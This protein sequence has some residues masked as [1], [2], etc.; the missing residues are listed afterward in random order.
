MTSCIKLKRK[1]SH[2]TRN[3]HS[4]SLGWYCLI[5]A[6]GSQSQYYGVP[7]ANALLPRR[8]NPS[9]S[10]SSS[11]LFNTKNAFVKHKERNNYLEG[12]RGGGDKTKRDEKDNDVLQ[13]DD[14]ELDAY[15][16]F[17]LAADGE[18]SSTVGNP[19]KRRRK[20]QEHVVEEAVQ[21]EPINDDDSLTE[22]SESDQ[23][24]ENIE[25]TGSIH[26]ENVEEEEMDAPVSESVE[27]ATMEVASVAPIENRPMHSESVEEET[28]TSGID[29]SVEMEP[30]GESSSAVVSSSD[31]EENEEIF[32]STISD[33]QQE[34]GISSSETEG[35]EIIVSELQSENKDDSNQAT[36]ADQ[37]ESLDTPMVKPSIEL[38]VQQTRETVVTTGRS[39]LWGKLFKPLVTFEQGDEDDSTEG[40]EESVEQTLEEEA[41]SETMVPKV[42]TT[43]TDESS[44]EKIDLSPSLRDRCREQWQKLKSSMGRIIEPSSSEKEDVDTTFDG[45]EPQRDYSKI[46][47]KYYA[48]ND[49]K[50]AD[51]TA[52]DSSGD[53]TDDTSSKTGSGWF[54]FFSKN[55]QKDEDVASGDDS[56][57]KLNLSIAP[58]DSVD[59]ETTTPENDEMS[60][61]EDD[62][63]TEINR[64][65][66][67]LDRIE[68]VF[69]GDLDHTSSQE[70]SEQLD[71]D[72]SPVL[73]LEIP[74]ESAHDNKEDAPDKEESPE[75]QDHDSVVLSLDI[76]VVEDT[77]DVEDK[78][79]IFQAE[80]EAEG[81]EEST[82]LSLDI[83]VVESIK[84]GD[85]ESQFQDE[86]RGNDSRV[87]L[88]LDIPNVE[89]PMEDNDMPLSSDA[90]G[91][92]DLSS[93]IP[94]VNDSEDGEEDLPVKSKDDPTSRKVNRLALS[95]DQPTRTVEI[96]DEASD[97]SG[98]ETIELEDDSVC[99]DEMISTDPDTT[100]LLDIDTLNE[101]FD[102]GNCE[103]VLLTNITEGAE[104]DGS[105]GDLLQLDSESLEDDIDLEDID[106]EDID[107]DLHATSSKPETPK[108]G[109]VDQSLM[110]LYV[111]LVVLEEM[112]KV[113]I[114]PPIEELLDWVLYEKP[115]PIFR[116]DFS[117]RKFLEMRGGAAKAT[118]L[119]STKVQLGDEIKDEPKEEESEE[120]TNSEAEKRGTK[121]NQN[122]ATPSTTHQNMSVPKVRP[123]LIYR[124]LL[125]YGR[126]GHTII[127]ASVFSVEWIGT[128]LPALTFLVASVK[129]QVFGES[130]GF[131]DVEES[132]A[133]QTTGF[134]DGTGSTVRGGKKKKAQT[135]K[136]DQQALDQLDRLGDASQARYYFVSNSFL[137]RHAI[138]P[139]S[140]GTSEVELVAEALD[141]V[142]DEEESDE[143]W[144]VEAL[145]RKEASARELA[146]ESPVEFSISSRGSALSVGVG[147]GFGEK[148]KK[149][150]KRAS[151]SE[152]SL[153]SA[154]SRTAKSRKPAGQRSS[155]RE[156][157]VVGRIRA[158]GANS[159]VGR[160]ILG[161]YPGDVPSPDEAA[162]PNG[163]LGLASKYG[164]GDW[165]DVDWSD[166]DDTDSL[167]Q[168]RG[169]P[170]RKRKSASGSVRKV[171]ESSSVGLGLEKIVRET[172]SSRT[173]RTRSASSRP[174]TKDEMEPAATKTVR[175]TRIRRKKLPS[176][177]TLKKANEQ[178]E[179]VK[180]TRGSKLLTATNKATSGSTVTGPAIESM[181]E[182]AKPEGSAKP[183]PYSES[184]KMADEARSSTETAPSTVVKR[185][186][187]QS[188]IVNSIGESNVLKPGSSTSAKES[189]VAGSAIKSLNQKA[190]SNSDSSSSSTD[191]PVSGLALSS[192]KKG[193]SQASNS[194]VG[195]AIGSIKES[196]TRAKSGVTNSAIDSLRKKAKEKSKS[197]VLDPKKPEGQ[198]YEASDNQDTT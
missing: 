97:P 151:I 119:G 93:D 8:R 21:E 148:S 59:T 152:V 10:S 104:D 106:N 77:E 145:T 149:S 155:D 166:A 109:F 32:E 51:E 17:L 101:N 169:K 188:D 100:T 91:A 48:M 121:T 122:D 49:S 184:S 172:Q 120:G 69:Q 143:D 50:T 128:Y 11:L 71:E 80:E 68:G 41:P 133:S 6:I 40:D 76:P 52:V 156:S 53:E 62:E 38:K 162:D 179:A 196:A 110:T 63:S 15:I 158:A 125:G 117:L 193:R 7:F 2:R 31:E 39:A 112:L 34:E 20:T 124:Y 113:Y 72:Q 90:H 195:P 29:D 96:V 18:D 198:T 197:S 127:M 161:A 138:G 147:F 35:D 25:E 190:K 45:R 135:Q 12:L 176:T 28:E 174:R 82:V 134:V 160:S 94:E 177:S 60:D 116:E 3:S 175:K 171:K 180:S 66:L 103:E 9:T 81:I 115:P 84:E 191:T 98:D 186:N 99:M 132:F 194:V 144:V 183:E 23:Q 170:R 30:V 46:Y 44:E 16:E 178:K 118:S 187:A 150:R 61:V 70:T 102:L 146:A 95:L 136:D 4:S 131:R 78:V 189:A 64:P 182:S 140:S 75:Q 86:E 126:A 87:V 73:S 89:Q 192:L 137:K 85:Y 47:Q 107:E 167:H 142:Q 105:L 58:S 114:L 1:R 33:Q 139:Y 13:M 24:E 54:A 129:R 168:R 108:I 37:E 111:T 123:N 42:T 164:Y 27:A 157:G 79:P 141:I 130:K 14:T 26:S 159:L 88:S 57:T 5:A 181:K 83:P 154:S 163:L 67:S 19:F 36:T 56:E 22:L 65:T 185:S 153:S 92:A 43:V 55:F 74:K 165:S 173:R